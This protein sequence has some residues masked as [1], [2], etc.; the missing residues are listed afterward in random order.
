MLCKDAAAINTWSEAQPRHQPCSLTPCQDMLGSAGVTVHLAGRNFNPPPFCYLFAW[1]LKKYKITD[2]HF[3]A[4]WPFTPYI[5]EYFSGPTHTS[6]NRGGNRL[7]RLHTF[8]CSITHGK[9]VFMYLCAYTYTMCED[10]HTHIIQH[11]FINVHM[12]ISIHT[13]TAHINRYSYLLL[14]IIL[15]AYKHGHKKSTYS[16]HVWCCP[17]CN[18]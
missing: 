16:S 4:L 2:N 15:K 7:G 10:S 18:T 8:L 9:P 3:R 5:L 13:Y 14:C 12:Y 1:S 17:L 6:V 11:M